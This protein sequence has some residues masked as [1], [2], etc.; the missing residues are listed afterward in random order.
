MPRS[1]ENFN[2]GIDVDR[3]VD[4]LAAG[5]GKSVLSEFIKEARGAEFLVPSNGNEH[6]L[7]VLNV[8]GKGKMNAA[9]YFSLLIF[10]FIHGIKNFFHILW[11]FGTEAHFFSGYRVL[12]R[13]F[14]SMECLSVNY[15]S[16]TAIKLIS[17]KRISNI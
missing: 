17:T 2:N 3:T 10:C 4:E 5:N 14:R 1:I 12:K 6:E 7:C 9:L 13:Y 16:F 15:I 8:N 11:K